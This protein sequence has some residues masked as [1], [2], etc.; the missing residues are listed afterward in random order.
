[1]IVIVAVVSKLIRINKINWNF[2][3]LTSCNAATSYAAAASIHI[4]SDWVFI[5]TALFLGAIDLE[6]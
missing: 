4:P 5:D 6:D 1:M 3:K 2:K